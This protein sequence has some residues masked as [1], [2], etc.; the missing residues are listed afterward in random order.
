MRIVTACA[1][2]TSTLSRCHL[3][4][5]DHLWHHDH[6]KCACRVTLHF[7]TMSPPEMSQRW[8]SSQRVV[9]SSV[10]PH[11]CS[12]SSFET[13]C[14]RVRFAVRHCVSSSLV[15]I[16]DYTHLRTARLGTS[17]PAGNTTD[18]SRVHRDGATRANCYFTLIVMLTVALQHVGLCKSP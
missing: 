10:K 13:I 18:Q 4:S 6:S 1:P 14:H 15:Y 2:S 8:P 17:C 11:F 16:L 5:K 9:V 12:G 7:A 3:Q